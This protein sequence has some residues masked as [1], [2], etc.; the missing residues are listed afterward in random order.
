VSARTL[1]W[2]LKQTVGNQTQK[3]ILVTLADIANEKRQCWPSHQY[4]ADMAECSKR[5]VIRHLIEL[6]KKGLIKVVR[7][8]DDAGL[9]SSNIYQLPDVTDWHIDVT[10]CHQ[11]SDTVAHN[12][13]IDTPT[14]IYKAAWD[15]W[16]AYR[17]EMKK[18]MTPRTVK[19]QQTLLSRYDFETQERIINQSIQN[20]WTGLF[21]PKQQKRKAKGGTRDRTLADDL[22]D[23]SWAH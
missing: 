13:P 8:V 12:T 4:I 20:G 18:K 23:T 11:G 9:K 15:E 22:S 10:D 2:A 1:F 19:M 17:K 6:E 14:S 16:V 3:L 21:E 7:R 5:S